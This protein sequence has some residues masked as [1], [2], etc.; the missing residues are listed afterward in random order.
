MRDL[1][2]KYFQ[3]ADASREYIEANNW[4]YGAFCP[5]GMLSTVWANTLEVN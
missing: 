3:D 1:T 2:A 5:I 4:P